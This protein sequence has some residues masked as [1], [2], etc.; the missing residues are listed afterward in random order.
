MQEVEV[1]V[2]R[3]GE[4]GGGGGVGPKLIH[5]SRCAAVKI[6]T[7]RKTWIK[8]SGFQVWGARGRARSMVRFLDFQIRRLILNPLPNS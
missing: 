4:G 3:G 1:G 5:S 6:G 7:E 8:E 2:S